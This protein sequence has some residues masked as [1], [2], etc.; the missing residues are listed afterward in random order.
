MEEWL[1]VDGYNVIGAHA[2]WASLSLDESR[3]L[4][5]SALAEYQAVTGREVTV[6]YDAHRS[7][8]AETK[9]I[10]SRVKVW[11]TREHETADQMIERLVRQHKK[12]QRRIYVA[13]SDFMEQRMIFG[14]GAY[15]VSSRELIQQLTAMD[16]KIAKRI[17]EKKE[18]RSTLGQGLAGDL[19]E[20][21][22]K[23][24]REK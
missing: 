9:T 17:R 3:D 6:V 8:G 5:V 16:K 13:T 4:L 19:L 7:P 10:D 12:S 21:L 22:E 23:W 24:R 18:R 15:R 14:Q 20:T 1:I 11:F 2:G